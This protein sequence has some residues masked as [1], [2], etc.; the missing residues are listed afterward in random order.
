[1]LI[2]TRQ[3]I[4]KCPYASH[5]LEPPTVVH[6]STFFV[7]SVIEKGEAEIEFFSNEGKKSKVI[8][9]DENCCLINFPF[10]STLYKKY[11]SNFSFRNVFVDERTMHECC[12][13]LKEGFYD[14][15]LDLEYPPAFLLSPPSV[16]YFA[17]VTS[18]LMKGKKTEKMDMVHK[19]LVCDFIS[20]YKIRKSSN[21]VF[22]KWINGLLRKLEDKDFITLS[23]EEMVRTTNYSHGYVNR[24]FKKYMGCSIKQYIIR[25]RLG[26]ATVLLTT[27]DLSVE[28]ISDNLNF[29]TTSNFINTFKKRYKIT[30]AKYRKLYG[31]LIQLDTYQ[32]WGDTI[33]TDK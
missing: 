8:T 25:K 16:I 30:P 24:E 23:V 2:H 11:S 13:F 28:E 29:S 18:T 26:L 17:E 1:M 33:E 3:T 7:I 22:P 20:Q 4:Y 31:S 19:A 6:Q 15:L 12:N 32:E 5:I 27:T 21:M 14:E 9:V 10:R